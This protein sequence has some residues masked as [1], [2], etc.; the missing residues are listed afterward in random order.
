M[1]RPS[2][3][4]MLFGIGRTKIYQL[5]RANV[6]PHRRVGKSIRIPSALLKEWAEAPEN[7]QQLRELEVRDQKRK[8]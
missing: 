7:A 8:Q 6:I 4:A 1:L 3:A 2:E 5:I